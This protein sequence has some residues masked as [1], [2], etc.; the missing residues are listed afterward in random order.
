METTIAFVQSVMNQ[1]DGG[2][3]FSHIER[4]LANANQI[5]RAHPEANT[6]VVQL[7]VLLHDIED[8]KFKGVVELGE[9]AV[10]THLNELSLS[11][12]VKDHV[13]FIIRHMSY[14]DSLGQTVEKSIEFKIV[15]DADRLDAIGAIG[16]ARAFNYGGHKNRPLYL[17]SKNMQAPSSK[18]EYTQSNSATIQH[19]YEKLL[20]LK[21]Q[22]NTEG[23]RQIAQKRHLFMENFLE[24]FY[25]EWNGNL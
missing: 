18:Q 3:D 24:Q 20:L 16:I 22:M 2:H 9:H 12:E 15:Q 11:Q 19:F 1:F 8:E 25:A 23:G 10:A 4:V 14:K 21:D 5:L 6:E 13:L 17:P 7:A